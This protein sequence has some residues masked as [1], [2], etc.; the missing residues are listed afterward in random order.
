MSVELHLNQLT[1]RRGLS[2]FYY[3]PITTLVSISMGSEDV[4]FIFEETS[5]DFQTITIQGQVSY[6]ITDVQKIAKLMDFSID[7]NTQNYISNDSQKL[8]QK[9]INQVHWHI[10]T[11]LKKWFQG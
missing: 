1:G 10:M 4:P 9:V 2:F 11:L 5:S 7:S 6:K 3:A 8:P